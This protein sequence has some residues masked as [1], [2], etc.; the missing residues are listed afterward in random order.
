M[1]MKIKCYG[2]N[3]EVTENMKS[4]VIKK[5]KSLE[6][7]LCDSSKAELQIIAEVHNHEQQAS[8]VLRENGRVYTASTKSIDFYDAVLST[9]DKLKR[10]I[11]SSK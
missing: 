4:F 7:Y 3:V 6:K 5:S 9:L 11:D 2:K 8:I 10:K 1:C